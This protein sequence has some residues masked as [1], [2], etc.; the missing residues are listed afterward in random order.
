M[1][2]DILYISLGNSTRIGASSHYL[3]LGSWGILLDAGLDPETLE[4]PNFD[5]V[6]DQPVNAIIISHAHLDH[7]GSLP[8]A[9]KY[10]PHARVYMT[11]ATVALSEVMLF[12][13][14]QVQKKRA[15]QENRKFEAIYTE[16]DVEK[17][18]YL[19]QSFKYNF[20][21]RI[22]GFL[23][24]K[25]EITFWDAGHILGSAGVQIT[26]NRKRFF[27]TGNTK[28]LS[29]FILKGAKYPAKTDVLIMESTYGDNELTPRIKKS[30]EM[31][32]FARFIEDQIRIGGSILIPVFALGRTQEIM[33]LI[34]RL[35]Q[36]SKIPAVPVYLT[37]FGIK[38]NRIYDRLLHKIYP[39]YNSKLLRTITYNTL[40]GKKFQKPAIILATS[41]MMMPN[42]ISY[43][44]ANDFLLKRRN[45][46]AIV[47]WADPETPGGILREKKIE[48]IKS[49]FRLERV[50]CSVEVFQ[51]SAHSHREELIELV[52]KIRPYK[53]VL[54]H[55]DTEALLWMEKEILGN[56]L[57][58]NVLIP[59]TGEF[60]NL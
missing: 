57:S 34:H 43:E 19:F 36:K 48:K 22:H 44:I 11:P 2:K 21:F 25:I 50:I 38:I 14:I 7:L 24:S 15:M 52:K 3:K 16:N 58:K 26:W 59:V 31:V 39:D 28:K 23:E 53:T 54:C 45:G 17:I 37:G 32:R 51:F 46:I 1:N 49:I 4:L 33:V 30:T 47:G 27:Y 12:H 35:I 29:Q 13:Y 41:G 5:V 18:L 42:T 10:F 56:N 6:K 8:V 55:G 60:N 20:P 40:Q 9:L